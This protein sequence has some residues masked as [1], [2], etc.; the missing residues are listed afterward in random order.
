MKPAKDRSH[1]W[2]RMTFCNAKLNETF[3]VHG[4]WG[5]AINRSKGRNDKDETNFYRSGNIAR[6]LSCLRIFIFHFQFFSLQNLSNEKIFSIFFERNWSRNHR[7]Q[8]SCEKRKKN[9]IRKI[10][11]SRFDEFDGELIQS[12]IQ[13]NG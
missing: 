12:R 6:V 11:C 1:S 13:T 10:K 2:F 5:C 7:L 9:R 3:I 4:W 8:R